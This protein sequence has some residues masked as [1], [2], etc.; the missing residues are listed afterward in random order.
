[1]DDVRG[2]DDTFFLEN[3][4]STAVN[5]E[6]TSIAIESPRHGTIQIRSSHDPQDVGPVTTDT[7]VLLKFRVYVEPEDRSRACLAGSSIRVVLDN[8]F[9]SHLQSNPCDDD[10]T[11]D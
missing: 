2:I 10:K 8:N 5:L 3:I 6:F 11:I 1:M 4:E 9:T 7:S